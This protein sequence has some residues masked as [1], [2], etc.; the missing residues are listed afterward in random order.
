MRT[1]DQEARD[2]PGAAAERAPRWAVTWHHRRRLDDDAG[3]G[4]VEEVTATLKVYTA[5]SVVCGPTGCVSFSGDPE[6]FDELL[7]A[8]F[9]DAPTR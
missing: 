5:G 2:E 8:V 4:V 3:Q 7:R 9:G 6:R 1:P